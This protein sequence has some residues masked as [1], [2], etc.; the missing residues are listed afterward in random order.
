MPVTYI[1]GTMPVAAPISPISEAEIYASH[2]ALWAKGGYRTVLDYAERDAIPI[3][4]RE[5]GM[6]VFLRVDRSLWRLQEDLI[7]WERGDGGGSDFLTE[8]AIR[9]L[10][11]APIADIDGVLTLEPGEQTYP[12]V[13]IYGDTMLGDLILNRYPIPGVDHPLQ[14]APYQ[15][16]ID[17]LGTGA[18]KYLIHHQTVPVMTYVLPHT[19]GRVPVVSLLDGT[20][21]QMLAQ[22]IP[23]ASAVEFTFENNTTFTAILK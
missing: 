3:A 10:D 5:S 23:T 2:W 16:V 18:E 12:W 19:F 22:V 15:W 17:Q 14:A 4:R 9:D 20:G 11:D 6:L 7:N 1:P 13:Y 8:W 21:R